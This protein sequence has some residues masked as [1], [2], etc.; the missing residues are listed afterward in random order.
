MSPGAGNAVY[1]V[2]LNSDT[3]PRDVLVAIRQR[4]RHDLPN[5]V[6]VC[7]LPIQWDEAYEFTAP[8]PRQWW[9]RWWLYLGCASND[10]GGTMFDVIDGLYEEGKINRTQMGQLEALVRVAMGCQYKA[11][12]DI[13]KHVILGML[14]AICGAVVPVVVGIQ[15][16]MQ[17]KQMAH[18]LSYFAI[19]LSL[20]QTV[21][22]TLSQVGNYSQS[23][24][25]RR[26]TAAEI[27]AEIYKFEA[28]A[29]EYSE[30]QSHHEQFGKLMFHLAEFRQKAVEIQYAARS[31][32]ADKK[33]DENKE[34][35][36]ADSGMKAEGKRGV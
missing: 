28:L 13:G 20:V 36:K 1:P 5:K 7:C 34:R 24:M 3:M 17:D 2:T 14:A 15:T 33:G 25:S 35:K 8:K 16:T 21:A 31:G 32:G 4:R 9:R 10:Y 22:V 18:Y 29:G 11:E 12:Q 26:M 27:K 30:P 6:S 23:A 19:M